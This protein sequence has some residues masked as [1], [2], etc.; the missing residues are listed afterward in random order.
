LESISDRI[1]K[2]ADVLSKEAIPHI[3]VDH[4]GVDFHFEKMD[5]ESIYKV[6]QDLFAGKTIK[7][8]K[9]EGEQGGIVFDSV[10]IKDIPEKDRKNDIQFINYFNFLRDKKNIDKH[11]GHVN[12]KNLLFRYNENTNEYEDLR[13]S[14]ET[15]PGSKKYAKHGVEYDYAV[16][17]VNLPKGIADEIIKWG[18]DNLPDSVLHDEEDGSKGRENDIH[19]TVLYGIKDDTASSTA[20]V[21]SKVKPFEIRLGLIN[22]FKDKGDYDVIKV[23]VESGDLERLHYTLEEEID[24]DNSY[25]TYSPHVTIAYVKK[26]SGDKF[27]GDES[28]KGKIFKVDSIEFSGRKDDKKKLPLGI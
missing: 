21:I 20:K 5:K 18:K 2:C 12:P 24:N 16:T 22:A 19:V 1:R 6:I 7:V 25:A 9:Y 13:H 14:G 10:N 23:Q 27:I 11:F 17:K 28:F 26:G 4:R 3:R 15:A 8:P